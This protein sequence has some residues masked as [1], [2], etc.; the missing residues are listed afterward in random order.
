M[1]HTCRIGFNISSRPLQRPVHRPCERLRVHVG[2]RR[3]AAKCAAG[4]NGITA[5]SFSAESLRTPHSGYHWD[6]VREQFFEGWYWKVSDYTFRVLKSLLHIVQIRIV[7]FQ[8]TES[9]LYD[10]VTVPGSTRDG[11]FD[12][13]CIWRAFLP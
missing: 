12:S 13:V 7:P 3:C 11:H 2:V 5:P 4:S 10:P 9:V 6:G 1:Q 8:W